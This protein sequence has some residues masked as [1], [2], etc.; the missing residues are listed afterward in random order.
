MA[1][2]N[3]CQV[4]PSRVFVKDNNTNVTYLID[5]GTDLCVYPYKNVNFNT[6]LVKKSDYKLFAANG[7]VINTYGSI[8]LNQNF[9]L[10]REFNWRFVIA[11][12]TRPIIGIDFL[13]FYN[14]LVDVRNCRLIDNTTLLNVNA[15]PVYSS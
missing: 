13:S 14:L 5:T 8:N 12:V 6:K 10:R 3:G 4:T 9:G 7:S 15:K 11:D 2:E 1:A